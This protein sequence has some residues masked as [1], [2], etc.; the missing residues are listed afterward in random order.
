MDNNY[1]YFNSLFRSLIVSLQI[2]VQSFT[3]D[4]LLDLGGF[5]RANIRD[6]V[7]MY[8]YILTIGPELPFKDWFSI[9]KEIYFKIRPFVQYYLANKVTPCEEAAVQKMK[10]AERIEAQ[11]MMEARVSI[12]K[13]IHTKTGR[14]KNYWTP[15]RCL[16]ILLSYYAGSITNSCLERYGFAE[17][18]AIM[19]DLAVILKTILKKHAPIKVSILLLVSLTIHYL[20]ILIIL[21]FQ[22]YLI[23][24]SETRN[25]Q[26]RTER[27]PCTTC[28][29]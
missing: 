15:E 4:M 24:R 12:Y 28:T 26:Q 13:K 2:C 17:A 29:D 21:L 7:L 8:M 10:G 3:M 11:N 18:H 14:S 5:G 19:V 6:S 1:K 20:I 23:L 16:Q 25:K 27:T 9:D 22:L